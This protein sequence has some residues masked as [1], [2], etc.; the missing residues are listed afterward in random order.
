MYEQVRIDK[1][2]WAVRIYKTRSLASDE[3][4]KGHVLIDD[5]PVK[6]SKM[7]KLNDRI[8]IKFPP[9]IRSFI[10][11]GLIEKRV[12]ASLAKENVKEITEQ[13]EFDKLSMTKN[14]YILRDK[15]T[16]RPTKK[17]RRIIDKF[18]HNEK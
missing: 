1:Y 17:E 3:C 9:M 2:L 12:S 15:G 10:V 4:K 5:A 13:S 16:G 11:T 8:D 6:P 18:K 7:I 14:N